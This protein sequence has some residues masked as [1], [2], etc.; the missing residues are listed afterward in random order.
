ME[1]VE[2]YRERLL[3]SFAFCSTDFCSSDKTFESL[4]WIFV[5]WQ[6]FFQSL[7]FQLNSFQSICS[8]IKFIVGYLKERIWLCWLESKNFTWKDCGYVLW[9][10]LFFIFSNYFESFYFILV[11]YNLFR[12]LFQK[13][14]FRN[15]IINT[16]RWVCLCSSSAFTILI[17]DFVFL[18]W[19]VPAVDLFA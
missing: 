1:W 12:L 16:S 5:N 4:S 11:G 6:C 10:E 17:L 2:K 19:F 13:E 7:S 14:T 15:V 3:L 18:T 8:L 9:D